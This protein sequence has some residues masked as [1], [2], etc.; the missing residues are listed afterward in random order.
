MRTVPVWTFTQHAAVI[1]YRHFET[2][3]RSH[4]QGLRNQELR[5]GPEE[6]SCHLLRD[7]SLKTQQ[8]LFAWPSGQGRRYSDSLRGGNVRE[9]MFQY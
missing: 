2:A 3:Y 8:S 7:V 5:N 9:R 6:C 1:S 4:L